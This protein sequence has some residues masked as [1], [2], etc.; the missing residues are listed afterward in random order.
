MQMAFNIKLRPGHL[1]RTLAHYEP[2]GPADRA[3]ADQT[4][5]HDAG[6]RSD[7]PQQFVIERS[8]A[9]E[10]D[11]FEITTQ[12]FELQYQYVF[13]RVAGLH[14]LQILQAPHK[15]PGAD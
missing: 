13:A 8:E 7:A 12:R 11:P 2:F 6:H 5:L 3:V 1:S 15:Q 10:N 14:L 9:G 4:R